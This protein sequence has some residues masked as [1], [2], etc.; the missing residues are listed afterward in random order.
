MVRLVLVAKA[1]V[2]AQLTELAARAC[3][4]LTE[5]YQ[6]Y[7]PLSKG[8]LLYRLRKLGLSR[9]Q[10]RWFVDNL[11]VRSAKPNH[12]VVLYRTCEGYAKGVNKVVALRDVE[13]RTVPDE[14]F[15]RLRSEGRLVC[16]GGYYWLLEWEGE[17]LAL[18]RECSEERANP[19]TQPA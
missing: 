15:G 2:D 7:E 17:P 11:T 3:R 8:T 12:Y 16:L 9:E 1:S 19:V 6:P 14:E 18:P 10:V 13:V 4:E 5:L